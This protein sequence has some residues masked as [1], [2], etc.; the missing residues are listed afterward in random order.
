MDVPVELVGK[1]KRQPSQQP[2]LLLD[3]GVR[4]DRVLL[5]LCQRSGDTMALRLTRLHFL[6]ASAHAQHE[7]V[8][9][10]ACALHS[11][12]RSTHR[13]QGILCRL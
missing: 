12:F 13:S 10:C 11:V 5:N 9:P 4:P 6:C 1:A 7:A 8:P 2:K 3:V